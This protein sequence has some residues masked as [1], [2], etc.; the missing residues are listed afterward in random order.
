MND[1]LSLEHFAS[2]GILLGRGQQGRWWQVMITLLLLVVSVVAR[3][4][5]AQSNLET[6]DNGATATIAASPSAPSS[7]TA[8]QNVLTLVQQGGLTMIP[9]GI[10]SFLLCIFIFERAINLRRGRVIPRPFVR[11]FLQQL[12]EGQLNRKEALSRCQENGSPVS[13][14]FAAGIMKWDR[15]A[16]EVE[17]AIIDTGERVANNLRK[18]LRMFNGVAT[19]SPLLGL[20]GTVT[21]IIRS[22]NAIAGSDAMGSP[23]L[24]ASGISEALITTA[25]GLSV[26]I[27]ALI[28][29]WYFA[30]RVD[31]L[32]ME[33]DS[34]GQQ[35]VL[36]V[37]SDSWQEKP[38][39]RVKPARSDAA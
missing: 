17:Q 1:R 11:R 14:V 19:I 20:L 29:F 33:I 27:P 22:F 7:G 28:A 18:Y 8:P 34:L 37:A 32:I 5:I 3:P 15:P 2:Y 4:A 12:S 25:A 16:V 36:A 30:S 6:T 38:I 24:L 23:E 10:C 31:R 35:I 21:G 9:L 26:A 13:E 39:K